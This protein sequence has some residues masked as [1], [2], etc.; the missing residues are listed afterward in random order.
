MWDR[1]TNKRRWRV[2][3]SRDIIG[4]RQ[5]LIETNLDIDTRIRGAE[6]SA[7]R[8]DRAYP[9]KI[10]KFGMDKVVNHVQHLVSYPVRNSR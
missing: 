2:Q 3:G 1:I 5:G 4:T 7:T 10:P 8:N 9:N 6:V